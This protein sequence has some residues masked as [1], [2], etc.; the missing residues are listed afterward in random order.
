LA[1]RAKTA[2]QGL[3]VFVTTLLLAAACPVSPWAQ[4]AAPKS[5]EAQPAAA[6]TRDA[7]RPPAQAANIQLAILLTDQIDGKTVA[8]E[9]V[10]L[11][12]AD[13]QLGRLRRRQPA[14]VD[15]N[16]EVDVTP[17][18]VGSRVRV[19]MTVSYNSTSAAEPRDQAHTTLF[20][21]TFTTFLDVGK[22]S[23]IV[24]LHGDTANR[25]VTLQVTATI[26]K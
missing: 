4:E 14:N 21:E 19:A 18:I 5:A 13:R 17:E 8:E 16:F 12:L 11:L 10:Q 25:R 20:V 7:P 6:P 22:P 2:L 15:K 1:E 23:N 26:I 24:E 9:P 3:R